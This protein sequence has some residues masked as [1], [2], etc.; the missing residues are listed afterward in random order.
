MQR[1]K[2]KAKAKKTNKQTLTN[3][4]FKHL[5]LYIRKS[6]SLELIQRW[7]K[8]HSELFKNIYIA[9]IYFV[10]D[11]R[12][13]RNVLTIFLLSQNNCMKDFKNFFATQ[14][15]I[16]EKHFGKRNLW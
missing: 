14:P 11:V 1:L 3:T 4:T 6:T 12:N 5:Q 9:K 16:Q 13:V 10:A 8:I 15:Y 7:Y 2:A